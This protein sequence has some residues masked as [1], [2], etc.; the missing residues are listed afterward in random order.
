MEYEQLKLTLFAGGDAKLTSAVQ[1]KWRQYCRSANILSGIRLIFRM[2]RPAA[3]LLVGALLH[4]C[5]WYVY[6][7]TNKEIASHI[8]GKCYALREDAILSKHFGFINLYLINT[9]GSNLCT[10]QEVTAA[11]KDEARYKSSGLKFPKCMWTPVARIA[12]ETTFRVTKV[13]DQPYG[14]D[15][16]C[17][18]VEVTLVT[19][20]YAGIASDIPACR[21]DFTESELWVRMKSG[22]EYIEPLELSD[23]VAKPCTAQ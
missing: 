17:W 18:K 22:D 11:T 23:L 15:G 4:G 2:R 13:T 20:E 1:I 8:V 5:S 9:P 14:G 16:R 12:K 3:I 7:A 6:D 21:F 10:P 19:G